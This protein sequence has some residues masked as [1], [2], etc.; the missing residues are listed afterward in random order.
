MTGL[1]TAAG[2]FVLD[3]AS[4]VGVAVELGQGRFKTMGVMDELVG[5]GFVDDV[6]GYGDIAKIARY[7]DGCVAIFLANAP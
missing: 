1:K 7:S 5:N 2:Q 6:F 4:L 3:N